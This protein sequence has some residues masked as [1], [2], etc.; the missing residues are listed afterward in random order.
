MRASAVDADD[1]VFCVEGDGALVPETGVL[2]RARNA[3][4]A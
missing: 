2:V 4:G 3:I 1:G